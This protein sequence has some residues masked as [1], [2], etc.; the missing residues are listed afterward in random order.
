MG[1]VFK[2][3]YNKRKTKTTFGMTEP[4]SR[5]EKDL[6]RSTAIS[7]VSEQTGVPANSVQ[8]VLEHFFGEYDK[9]CH[10]INEAATAN[11][12]ADTCRRMGFRTFGEFLKSIDNI[13]K[14]EKGSL[15]PDPK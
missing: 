12:T 5:G 11:I 4:F 6:M 8:L 7:N 15:F 1:R 9:W 3:R 2:G 10:G 13:K 14:A